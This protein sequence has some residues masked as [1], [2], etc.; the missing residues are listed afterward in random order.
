M[1]KSTTLGVAFDVENEEGT[2]P[3]TLI[4]R[5][6]YKAEITNATVGPTK[7]GN[8][9]MVNLTW[10]ITEGDFEN[11]LVFQSII[12]QHTERAKT[13]SASDGNGSRTSV[14]RAASLSR[15]PTWMC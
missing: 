2:P 1:E 4:P 14:R 13:H 12:I 9:L 8:A 5:G 10:T 15:S 11:R 7:K 6:K 3:I